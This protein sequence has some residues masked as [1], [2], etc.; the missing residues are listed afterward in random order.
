MRGRSIPYS[1][2]ELAWIEANRTLTRAD[3]HAAF[4]NRFNR[5]D[6]SPANF[7]ALCVRKGWATGRDGRLQPG[8][9]PANKG[10]RCAPGTGGRHPNARASHFQAGGRHGAAARHHRPIGSERMSKEGYLERKIAE[11]LKARAC[12]RAVHVINWEAQHG[13]VPAHHCLKCLGDKAN[14]DAANWTLIPR[15][16]LPR[17]NGGRHKRHLAFDSAEPEVR[18]ALLTVAKLDHRARQLRRHPNP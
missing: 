6:V 14:T 7:K 13:P 11:G 1:P 2:A 10:R 15:T 4:C 5:T 3:A 12:W 16:I 17:L 8:N 18:P 9:V